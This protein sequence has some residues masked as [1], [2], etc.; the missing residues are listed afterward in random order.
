MK[1]PPPGTAS[2]RRSRLRP[3][4][5]AASA[6]ALSAVLMLTGLVAGATAAQA[7]PTPSEDPFYTPPAPLPA[8]GP[9]TVIRSRESRFSADSTVK[10]WQVLYKSE[11]A[12]G[13]S[14][15]VSGTV[16]VPGARWTGP[17]PRP[18]VSYGVGTRGIGDQCAPSYTLSG[19][20][21]YES[22]LINQALQKGWA[23]AVTDM[24]GL[25]TPGMHTYEVG[26]S[27]G[28][29]VLDIA[30]AAQRLPGTGL[31]TATPVGLWGYSQGGTSTGWAAE[32]APTYAPELSLKGAAAGGVPADLI[33]VA[34]YLDGGLGMGLAFTAA[35]GYDAAYPELNLAGYLNDAGRALLARGQSL[36][37]VSADGIST[38]L[39]T[40]FKRISDYTT[41]DPLATPAWQ[42]RL[43]ENR[44]GSAAPAVPVFQGH[45]LFDEII[46]L[47]QA[48]RLRRDWCARGANV[49]WKVYPLAEHALG[50]VGSMPDA[51]RFLA[52]R[53][54][55]TPVRGNC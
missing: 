6:A 33:V 5:R 42:R 50:L 49:T 18:L 19:G 4:L 9:G 48:D 11:S 3:A 10:S 7:A 12:T 55:G 29:A 47:T 46:P 8:G 52:D 1:I 53:F 44:L 22:G 32:L 35:V 25:G 15:A 38:Y 13:A 24:E 36:C 31:T 14:I 43:N 23:V 34:R 2:R 17:G 54:A 20:F 16:L 45:A 27:Q 39:G 30:R 41:T 21:D 51:L 37:L 28:K 40:A 26:R